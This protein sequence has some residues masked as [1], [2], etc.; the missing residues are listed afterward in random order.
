[1][2]ISKIGFKTKI[3]IKIRGSRTKQPIVNETQPPILETELKHRFRKR[4]KTSE[5]KRGQKRQFRK[6][7]AIKIVSL[8]QA[9][10]PNYR[11]LAIILTITITN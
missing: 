3:V 4:D 2:R 5:F 10:W 9:S 11:K 7:T 6:K 1:M 8:I